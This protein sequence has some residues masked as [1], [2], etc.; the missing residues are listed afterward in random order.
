MALLQ[1]VQNY[2][3]LSTDRGYQFKFYCDKCHNGF[4]SRFQMSTVGTVGS[5]LRAAGDLFGGIFGQAGNS[6]YEIQRAVGG[7]AHDDAL[8]EAVAEVKPHFTQCVRCGRWVCNTVCWNTERGL[9]SECAPQT[10]E[11]IAAA[12]AQATVEQIHSKVRERDQTKDLDLDGKMV[13]RCPKCRAKT[14]GGKFCPECGTT[15]APKDA[16]GQCGAKMPA[17]GKFCPECGARQG[18]A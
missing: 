10:E 12:Q 7:K 14:A 8:E 1:F 17:G 4:M 15:L 16:C 5:A 11:E 9:C 6:A 3:D 2:D 18:A 13:A